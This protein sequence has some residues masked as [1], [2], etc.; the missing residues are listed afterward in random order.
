MKSF[1]SGKKVYILTKEVHAKK[2][3]DQSQINFGLKNTF[4]GGGIL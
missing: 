1:V 3:G 4:F 2:C